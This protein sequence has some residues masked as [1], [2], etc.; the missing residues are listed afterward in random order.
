MS[1]I[2]KNIRKAVVAAVTGLT[3]TGTNVIESRVY[4]D[5]ATSSLSVYTPSDVREEDGATISGAD[6]RELTIVIEARA[7][8]VGLI[9]D[10]LDTIASEVVAAMFVDKTLG[11][12]VDYLQYDS[13]QS[14]LS[15]D[16]EKPLGLATMTFSAYYRVA[17][18]DPDTK[19]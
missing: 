12:T 1:T 3:T 5:Q 15:D 14:E 11:G 6:P 9:E 10:T 19:V 4:P 7:K 17:L 13:F 8:A 18:N 16:A 2:R